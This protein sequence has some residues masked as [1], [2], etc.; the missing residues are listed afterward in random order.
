MLATAGQKELHRCRDDEPFPPI[1]STLPVDRL[2]SFWTGSTSEM[3]H[4]ECD[5]VIYFG[6]QGQEILRQWLR[7]ELEAYLFSPREVMTQRWAD[8]RSKP[9]CTRRGTPSWPNRPWSGWGNGYRSEMSR[10]R[11]LGPIE[12]TCVSYSQRTEQSPSNRPD[13]QFG[14]AWLRC[15]GRF[16]DD[17]AARWMSTPKTNGSRVAAATMAPLIGERRQ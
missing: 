8:Q 2:G 15:P 14:S 12:V 4:E 3:E 6:P 5:R 9:R 13:E 1:A 17:R 16:H 7:T 11:R 10:H